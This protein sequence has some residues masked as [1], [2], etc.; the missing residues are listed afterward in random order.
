MF[1]QKIIYFSGCHG[2]GKTSIV[3]EL[4]KNYIVGAVAVDLDQY[5]FYPNDFLRG[6]VARIR[7]GY[8][9]IKNIR[10]PFVITD[11]SQFD[12]L[13]YAETLT[14]F[15]YIKQDDLFMIQDIFKTLPE[16][17]R[18]SGYIVFLNPSLNRVM[19]NLRKRSRKEEIG[20]IMVDEDFVC[21]I[22]TNFQKF[23]T[24][25][26]KVMH[27]LWLDNGSKDYC[28][29]TIIEKMQEKCWLQ[30]FEINPN[31]VIIKDTFGMYGKK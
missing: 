15:G 23:Y 2:I 17:Y 29:E 28:A 31:F 1:P 4:V 26:Q 11:R 12:A 5:Y 16:S 22:I 19:D 27:V 6:E 14:E 8:E 13:V 18:L 9:T 25:I 7:I 10:H 30:P 24:Q 21:A 20:S 3:R